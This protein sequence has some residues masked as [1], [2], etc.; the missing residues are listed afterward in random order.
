LA[1]DVWAIVHGFVSISHHVSMANQNINWKQ[2][3]IDAV[4]RQL[5]AY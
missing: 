1:L 3:A 2:Q 4:E 5:A